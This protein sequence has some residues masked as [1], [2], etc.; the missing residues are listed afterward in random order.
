MNAAVA[1]GALARPTSTTGWVQPSVVASVNAYRNGA[2]ARANSTAPATSNRP[3]RWRGVSG[4][5]CHASTKA[6][7]AIGIWRRNSARHP[8]AS[9]IGPPA[10]TPMTGP[11]APTMVQ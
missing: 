3:S 1:M 2:T 10:T 11:P 7:M 5:S 9:T 8:K 6:T 4:S